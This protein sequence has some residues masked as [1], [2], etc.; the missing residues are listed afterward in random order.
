MVESKLSRVEKI[1]VAVCDHPE[2]PQECEFYEPPVYTGR[3]YCIYHFWDDG[4][5]SPLIKKGKI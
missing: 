2:E 3:N 5:H 1:K 4:C